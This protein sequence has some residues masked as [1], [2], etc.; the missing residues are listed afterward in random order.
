VGQFARFSRAVHAGAELPVTLTDARRAVELLTAL[1]ASA[2]THAAVDLPI[3][4]GHSMY[5]GWLP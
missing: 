3:G 1:Y 4:P 5:Q 2:R